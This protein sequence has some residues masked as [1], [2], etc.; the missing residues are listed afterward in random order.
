M[1]LFMSC[2]MCHSWGH[3]DEHGTCEV[4]TCGEH[5]IHSYGVDTIKCEACGRE[6]SRT[7]VF[8]R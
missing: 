8:T 2:A 5:L 7:E 4:C 6:H 1:K 3:T